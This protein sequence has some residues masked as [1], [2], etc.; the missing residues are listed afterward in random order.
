MK[1]VV[2]MGAVPVKREP[3]APA[4]TATAAAAEAPVAVKREPPGA[5]FA[6]GPATWQ[7]YVPEGKLF[8]NANPLVAESASAPKASAPAAG[9]GST[10]QWPAV[11]ATNQVQVHSLQDDRWKSAQQATQRMMKRSTGHDAPQGPAPVGAIMHALAVPG[12]TG[13]ESEEDNGPE[14]PAHRIIPLE[15]ANRRDA[16]LELFAAQMERRPL[17]P[18]TQLVL[19]APPAM[20][21]L[22]LCAQFKHTTMPWWKGAQLTL[23]AN[24]GLDLPKIPLYTR[25]Y[26]APFMREPDPKATYERP[27][28]NLDREPYKGE[29]GRLRCIAHRLSEKRFGPQG[30]YRLRELLHSAT[31]VQINAAL[32]RVP[33]K[34]G[35]PV[36]DPR[37][38]LPEVPEVC[39]MCHIWMVFEESL[40]QKNRREERL[41]LQRLSSPGEGQ[42]Q[43]PLLVPQRASATPPDLVMVLNKFMVHFDKPGE[44]S[45]F[46]LL[47]GDEVGLGVWGPFPLW[48]ERN[49]VPWVDPAGT[50][51]RGFQ[52]LEDMLF[53]QAP[54]PS[55][56]TESTQATMGDAS[57]RSNR[58]S[59]TAARTTFRP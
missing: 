27:C 11:L 53:Q 9:S 59:A 39:V 12:G 14:G 29:E 44:Y 49:Y 45:R 20:E 36:R 55:R 43:N 13:G 47:A 41:L 56:A 38:H 37:I 48:Q 2:P 31:T 40:N 58:T 26:L 4:A 30:A 6:E 54:A 3:A 57:T 5:S 32:Q 17:R 46:A 15:E 24:P 25:A 7:S 19:D 16:D 52:E 35:E 34:R 51:L 8:R 33:S 22:A 28:L 23:A 50:G 10:G 21:V 18:P 42:P 1:K